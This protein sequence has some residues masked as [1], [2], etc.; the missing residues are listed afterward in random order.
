MHI[1]N[2][3]P[4]KIV[5]YSYILNIAH[6]KKIPTTFLSLNTNFTKSLIFVDLYSL[7]KLIMFMNFIMLAS[8]RI[9]NV[10]T[11]T[12]PNN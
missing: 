2:S 8:H 11:H 7:W 12:N 10:L 1:K 4:F 6:K 3:I 5:D 9:M